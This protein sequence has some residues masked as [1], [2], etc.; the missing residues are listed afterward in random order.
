MFERGMAIR[1]AK[2]AEIR[3]KA[4]QEGL[5]EGRQEENQRIKDL[6]ESYGVSLSPDVAS[7]ISGYLT[8]NGS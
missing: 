4:R 2:K 6:L 8:Q 3:E 7:A 5:Q 1:E